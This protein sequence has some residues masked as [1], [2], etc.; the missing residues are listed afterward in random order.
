VLRRSVTW[1]VTGTVVPPSDVEPPAAV[2][3]TASRPISSL[4]T[5]GM[6]GDGVIDFATIG[7]WVRDAG[8]T[9]D[10]EVENLQSGDLGHRR[11]HSPRAPR[12]SATGAFP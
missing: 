9:G 8:Y 10:M 4:L 12:R 1:P 6:M 5:R 11:R 7:T 3:R 2:P